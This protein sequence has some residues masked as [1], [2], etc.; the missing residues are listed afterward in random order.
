MDKYDQILDLIEHPENYSPQQIEALMADEELREV[1]DLMCET[2]SALYT[3]QPV[4]VEAEWKSFSSRHLRKR[5]RL[6]RSWNRA[7]SIAALISVSVAALAIGAGVAMKVASDRNRVE[8][9][10]ETADVKAAAEDAIADTIIVENADDVE[11]SPVLFEDETLSSILEYVSGF[12]G[13]ELRYEAPESGELR[14]YYRWDPALT[15]E[16]VLEQLNN[17]GEINLR[18]DEGTIIVAKP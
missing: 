8:R 10:A 12:Y 1:Y 18:L 17:F 2:G 6:P 5:F 15:L 11:A 13:K 14:L 4:D 3:P 7:A 9:I 16:E